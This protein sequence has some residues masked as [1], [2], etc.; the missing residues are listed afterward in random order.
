MGSNCYSRETLETRIEVCVERGNG[1]LKGSTGIP[2]FDHMLETLVRYARLDVSI[3]VEER[4]KVDDHHIV[5]DA[6]IA[7]G[8]ALDALLGDRRGL[9]RFGWALIPMDDALAYAAVDLARRPYVVLKGLEWRRHEIGGLALENIAHFLRT[10]AL[11]ARFTLHAGIVYGENEHHKAEALFK[12]VGWALR[13]AMRPGG[14]PSTK[15]TLV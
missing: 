10:L 9:Q 8:R 5:E 2:F 1:S 4:K 3:D 11:E 7:L 15:G 13:E 12:A 6:G 14:A